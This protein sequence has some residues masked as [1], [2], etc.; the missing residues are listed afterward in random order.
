MQLPLDQHADEWTPLTADAQTSG[1][2]Y[3]MKFS[4]PGIHVTKAKF[5][6]KSTRQVIQTLNCILLFC[7]DFDSKLMYSATTAADRGLEQ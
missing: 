5:I 1:L 3:G 2:I 4:A 7:F 6:T